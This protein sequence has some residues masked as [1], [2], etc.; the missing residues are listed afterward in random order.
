MN[1]FNAVGF[2]RPYDKIVRELIT[3]CGIAAPINLEKLDIASLQPR[4][5]KAI[6]DTGATTTLITE[7]VA[8][9]CGLEPTGIVEIYT[10]GSEE[11]QTVDVFLTSIFLPNNV[12][13][14]ELHVISAAIA[15]GADILIG[16]Y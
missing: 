2:I 12:V 9:E 7:R 15:N 13:L 14:P 10:V 5:Y 16:N 11:A 8:V 3:D 6:W 1:S 4:S